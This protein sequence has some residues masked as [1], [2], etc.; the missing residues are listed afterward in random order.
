M[1][2]PNVADIL[3]SPTLNEIRTDL[4]SRMN[5]PAYVLTDEFAGAVART[6]WEVQAFVLLDL[7]GAAGNAQK[8][9]ANSTPAIDTD[10]AWLTKLAHCL[11]ERDRIVGAFAQQTVTL[12]CAAGLSPY[13]ITAER[14]QLTNAA[15]Q[16]FTPTT[17]GTLSGGGTLTIQVRAE[18]AGSAR[19]L[20]N[21]IVTPNLAGVTVASA[22]TYDPGTGPLYGADAES[23]VALLARIITR[24]PDL[25]APPG[26]EDRIVT[27]AKASSTEITR[28]K[29]DIDTVNPG[30]VIVTVAG[31][32]GPVSGGAVS[33]AQAYID[34]RIPI[35]DYPTVQN[36]TTMLVGVTAGVVTVRAS[37]LVE[38][39][40]AIDAPANAPPLPP[41]WSAVLATSQIGG[42]VYVSKLEQI[43]KDLDGVIDVVNLALNGLFVGQDV[44]LGGT[45]VP[46]K[47]G[48]LAS[49]LAWLT[50]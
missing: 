33:G 6:I 23:D 2:V 21:R 5:V 40:A 37:K 20:V 43:L 35:T 7:V 29:L 24:W 41:N 46:I 16:S 13:V 11:F 48:T 22:A 14:G 19:G 31:P 18:A 17:G 3:G 8:M 39:Q 45:D 1:S 12:A 27:W 4:I 38:I 36:A 30:G 25:S 44:T 49:Q 50:V 47:T 28:V 9:L 32:S 26:T 42:T 10:G 15:G 34:T